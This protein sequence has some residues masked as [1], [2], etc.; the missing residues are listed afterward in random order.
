MTPGRHPR[1]LLAVAAGGAVG[2]VVRYAAT[3]L[4]ADGPGFAWTT[5]AVNVSGSAL[6]AALLL[7]PLARRSPVWAAALGPGVLGGYTTFS[8]TS[9]QART[10]L[11]DGRAG[12]ALAYVGGTLAACLVAVVLVGLLAPPLPAEDE[13]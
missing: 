3:E 6:L 2:A 7:L 13:L 10:L 1:L 8:A 11:A 4:V 9:E 5:F 12:L